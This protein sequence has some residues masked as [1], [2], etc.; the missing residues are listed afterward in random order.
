[1]QN[2][3]SFFSRANATV[4][5][6]GTDW[7]EGPSIAVPLSTPAS[8]ALPPLDN[9]TINNRAGSAPV[10]NGGGGGRARTTTGRARKEDFSNYQPI[11]AKKILKRALSDDEDEE[12]QGMYSDEWGETT[13]EFSGSDTV[14]SDAL[15]GSSQSDDGEPAFVLCSDEP[16]VTRNRKKKKK[17]RTGGG[18]GGGHGPPGPPTQPSAACFGCEFAWH[19]HNGGVKPGPV[20]ECFKL[21]EQNYGQVDDKVLAKMTRDFFLAEVFIPA[22][23]RGRPLPDW[24]AKTILEH[25]QRHTH[26]PRPFLVNA[27]RDLEEKREAMAF[28]LF[29]VDDTGRKHW[30]KDAMREYRE[31][32]KLQI[33]LYSKPPQSMNFYNASHDIDFQRMGGFAKSF[34][35]DGMGN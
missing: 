2:S 33:Q 21:M 35:L 10:I 22:K 3:D 24:T 14:G 15:F 30:D 16:G 23:E 8:R 9:R 26:D 1:M 19:V 5:N 13:M 32:Y 12:G 34:S 18:S 31:L 20:T 29:S 4:V 11:D 7:E 6:L 28:F 17:Q 27:I 25:I